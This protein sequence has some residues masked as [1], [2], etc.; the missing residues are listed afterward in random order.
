MKLS[1]F[2]DEISPDPAR[3]IALAAQWQ[4]PFV[5][6]RGLA[7]G[8]FPRVADDELETFANRVQDAGLKVSGVSP[9]LCKCPVDDPSVEPDLAELL[10]RACEWALRLGTDRVSAFAFR[11]NDDVSEPPQAVVDRLGEMAATTAANGCRLTL[12]NEAVCWG[13]TGAEAAALIRRVA[14]PYLTL[15][16]DPGNSAMAG[17]VSPYPDEYTT[18][19]DLVAHVHLKNC[20]DNQWALIDHGPIDWPGQLAAL[21]ADNYDGFIVIETHLKQRPAGL[22]LFAGLDAQESNTRHNLNYVRSLL[23]A[24]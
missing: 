20:Q 13:A 22:D 19:K 24:Q 14:S 10:P 15:L 16:W 8:R 7:G 17:A 1:I 12:E 2:T 3:A 5:E 23:A 4:V 21:K 11:R 18:L 6:V 9:G